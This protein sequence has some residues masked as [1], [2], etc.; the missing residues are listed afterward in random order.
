MTVSSK[1]S[2]V[3][4][5]GNGLTS[6]W[7]IPFIALDGGDIQV[8]LTSPERETHQVTSGFSVDLAVSEL[9]FPS[10]G[11]R[12]LD[13]GWKLVI[14]R[15]V[16]P[17]Q[18]TDL[19]NQGAFYAEV[20]EES[21]DRLTMITQQHEEELSRAVKVQVSESTLGELTPD[22]VLNAADTAVAAAQAAGQ[23]RD[24][25]QTAQL[26]AEGAAVSAVEQVSQVGTAAVSVLNG[27]LVEAEDQAFVYIAAAQES[28]NT[29]SQSA[30]AAGESETLAA[31]YAA[32]AFAAQAPAWDSASTYT[33]PDV[34][35]FTDGMSYRCKGTGVIAVEPPSDTALWT[36]ITVAGGS[37]FEIDDDGNYMP[38]AYPSYGDQFEL[39]GLG[40]IMPLAI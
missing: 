31:Q 5:E 28:A 27:I 9:I 18:E 38:A 8:F 39:D 40:D 24:F 17:L 30:N 23:A 33:Y 37:F 25:A 34:V 10:G 6:V 1:L 32:T 15:R 3:V 4:Y 11:G 26:A 36:P 29:A 13:A 20:I 16:D 35:A 14:L 21:L 7:P 12:P 22:E 2:K 19:I